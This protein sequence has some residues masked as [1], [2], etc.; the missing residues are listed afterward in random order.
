MVIECF[1]YS[2]DMKCILEN[3]N[4]F[5]IPVLVYAQSRNQA[6]HIVKSFLES[7]KSGWKVKEVTGFRFK[8]S[9]SFLTLDDARLS[10]RNP[11]G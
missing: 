6:V 5:T 11:V 10:D 2:I 8:L 3:G 7:G 4:L 9:N 1:L